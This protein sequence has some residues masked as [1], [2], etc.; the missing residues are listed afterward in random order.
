MLDHYT[1]APSYCVQGMFCFIRCVYDHNRR[2]PV[3]QAFCSF[4]FCG[5]LLVVWLVVKEWG[6]EL[7]SILKRN[8]MCIADKKYIG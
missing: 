4:N 8:G 1:T 7:V 6:W 5:L 2:G 3:C